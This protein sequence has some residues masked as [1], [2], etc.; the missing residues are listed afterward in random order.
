MVSNLHSLQGKICRFDTR[1]ILR[2]VK[3]RVIGTCPLILRK[4]HGRQPNL[5]DGMKE[6]THPDTVALVRPNLASP[7][8]DYDGPEYP[9]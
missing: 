1:F 4:I 5:R 8:Q 6:A 7:R 3:E 9:S 2:E